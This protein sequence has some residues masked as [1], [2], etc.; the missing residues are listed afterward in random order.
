MTR[1]GK[2]ARL[3]LAVRE[4]LNHRLANGELAQDL[5]AWLNARADVCAVLVASFD[6]RDISEQNLSEWKQGGFAEWHR[7]QETC[8]WLRSILEHME[9]LSK[10]TGEHSVA[11]LLSAPVAAVVGKYIESLATEGMPKDDKARHD[12][13]LFL[14]ELIQLRRGDHKQ[15]LVRLQCLRWHA[16][17]VDQF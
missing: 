11:D 14:R 12:M 17:Q 6:G 10:A 4:E 3:P 9:G 13:L 16:E 2:I 1:I 8:G 5:V 7:H 15:Q